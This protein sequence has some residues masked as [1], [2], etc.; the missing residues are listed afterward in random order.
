MRPNACVAG[1][2]SLL[3]PGLGQMVGG[4]GGRGAAILVGAIIIGSL[5]LLFL[6]AFSIANP[7]PASVWAYWIPRV[8]H[9]ALAVWSVA[10]W[11]WAVIDAYRL[12]RLSP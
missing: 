7:D 9:D 10:F 4:K 2:L 8:G 12:V 11:V 5:N 1:V 6:L 3:I